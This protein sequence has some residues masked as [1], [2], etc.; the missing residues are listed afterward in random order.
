MIVLGIDVGGTK[1]RVG[2]FDGIH[3]IA[4]TSF[5]T[6]GFDATLD[7]LT[8]WAEPY[9]YRAIGVGCPGPLDETNGTVIH[10]DTL[11]D[12]IGR[13]LV[14]ALGSRTNRPVAILNDADA[15]LL[16]EMQGETREPTAMLTF[17]TGVGGAFWAGTDRYRGAFGEHPE[18][19]HM[20][21]LPDG[22]PCYC[23][24][25]GCLESEASGTALNA[26][27]A[28][29]GYADLASAVQADDPL[30]HR[31]R[32]AIGRAIWNLAHVL[33]PERVI[34]GGGLMDAFFDDLVPFRTMVAAT[35][36]S[37]IAPLRVVPAR[38]GNRA[39]VVGAADHARRRFL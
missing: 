25:C 37:L 4:E 33:R 38:L 1:T 13:D 22:R 18:I 28:E 17:G 16:G 23:G 14:G 6:E 35:A 34:L 27:A 36:P 29:A 10:P 3:S 9:S 12:W 5:A 7:R 26:R 19:G 30:V 15:A 20:P 31:G 2:V 11:P 24:L 32:E 39:G 21:V 8:Q